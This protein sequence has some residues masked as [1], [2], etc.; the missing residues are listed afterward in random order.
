MIFNAFDSITKKNFILLSVGQAILCLVLWSFFPISA[1]PTPIEIVGAWHKMATNEGLL[2]ELFISATTILKAIGLAALISFG[3]AYLTTAIVFKP[4]VTWMTSMRFLGFAG[5]TFL[6]TLWTSNS[7]ELKLW[8]LTFGMTVFLL[9]SALA[10]VNSVT[11]EQIDYARTLQLDGWQIT[12]EIV[13]RGKLDEAIDIIRQNAA[14]GWTL[15][16]MVEG[17]SRSEGGIGA[18]LLMKGKY[19]NLNELFAIQLTILGYGI[20]QDAALRYF[21]LVICP[22]IEANRNN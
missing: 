8:L 1:V 15:L 13:V 9:S 16:S 10:M 18:M 2:Y 19:L 3:L 11:Q 5:I 4:V 20:F 21:R 6:F 22:Y 12:W 7:G 17:L 14:V